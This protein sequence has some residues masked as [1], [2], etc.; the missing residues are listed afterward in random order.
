MSTHI[1]K[2]GEMEKKLSDWCGHSSNL[3]EREQKVIDAACRLA[4]NWRS[5]NYIPHYYD[6][7]T[8][9]DAVDEY[10]GRK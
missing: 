10:R 1:I 2:K 9:S 5:Q 8:L 4:D 7:K 6:F 3:R